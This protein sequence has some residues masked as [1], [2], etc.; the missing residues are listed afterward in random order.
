M[1]HDAAVAVAD[2]GG[3][4]VRFDFRGVGRSEGSWGDGVGETEDAVAVFDAVAAESGRPPAVVGYSFGGAVACR[5]AALRRPERL[6]LLATPLSPLCRLVPLEDAPRVAC[7]VHVVCG[8]RD[9]HVPVADAE[10]L[11]A[12]FR[13]PA[14]VAWV[15]DAGHLLAADEVRRAVPLALRALGLGA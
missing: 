9:P 7:P 12:A 4:A 2:A 3:R 13:P 10:R 5:L 14:P 8:T 11:A 6:V 1:V 15:E